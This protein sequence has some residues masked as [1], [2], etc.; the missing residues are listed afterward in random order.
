MH[1]LARQ[2]D[3]VIN[4]DCVKE[5]SWIKNHTELTLHLITV[6]LSSGISILHHTLYTY[7]IRGRK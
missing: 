5:K 4:N 2:Q 1:R 3:T 7:R 6:F